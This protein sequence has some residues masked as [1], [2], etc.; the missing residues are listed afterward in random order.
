MQLQVEQHRTLSIK[1]KV[2]QEKSKQTLM[3]MKWM[4]PTDGQLQDMLHLFFLV[5]SNA[6]VNNEQDSRFWLTEWFIPHM[7]T[8]RRG[9]LARNSFTFWATKCFFFVFVLLANDETALPAE[10]IVLL[11]NN[12]LTITQWQVF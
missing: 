1:L 4:Y 8:L 2:R 6:L 9:S 5:N 11:Y 7:R 12:K 10:A 3:V